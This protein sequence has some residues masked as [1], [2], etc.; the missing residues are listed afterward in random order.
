[1]SSESLPLPADQEARDRIRNNLDSTL[2]VEAGAGTGKTTELVNR[3][4][5]LVATGRAEMRKIAAITFTEAAA[6]ELR[7]RVREELEKAA[8][9]ENELPAAERE[10]CQIALADVDAA[11]IATLHG[12]SQRILAAHPLEAGL[13]PF[14]E[15]QDEVR[16]S[17]AFEERW[18]AF[19]DALLDDPAYEDVL[20]RSSVLGLRLDHL[21]EIARDFHRNWDRL[22]DIEIETVAQPETDA[23][24]LLQ[25]LDDACRRTGCCVDCD[26]LLYQYLAGV[27]RYC[28]RLRAAKTDLD[29]LRI[30]AARRKFTTRGGKQD[31]WSG[32]KPADIRASLQEA[33]EARDALLREERSAVLYQLL[34]P[35]RLFVLEYADERRHEGRVE[36]HDLLVRARDLLRNNAS[37]RRAVSD[38][39]SHLL[40]DEF[41]DTDP[42]QIDVAMLLACA[43]TDSAP[44][45]QEME[46]AE[47]KLFFV[48][49]PKQS[50]YRFRRA[51]IAL[52][53]AVQQRFQ[54]QTVRLT[55]NFR[56]LRPVIDWVNAVFEELIGE[57]TQPGQ[58]TYMA[59][60]AS[61]ES[62]PEAGVT[63]H[64]LGE[65]SGDGTEAIRRR[66][67]QEIAQTVQTAKA[68]GWLVTDED[69]DGNRCQRPCRYADI[70]LLMPTRTASAQLERALEEANIPYRVE[71]RSL[72]YETQEVRDLL[73]VLR[74]IDDPTDE[75]ALVGSLRAPAFGCGDDDLLRFAQARGRWDYRST[76]SSSLPGDDPVVAAMKALHELHKARWW[77]PVNE[78]V[79]TVIRERRF[80]ELAFAHRRPREHWQRLRFVLDQARAFVESGGTSLRQFID[81]ADLQAQERTRVVETIVPEADD[82]A[83][84]ILTVHASKG[85]EFRIVFLVGLNVT[86]SGPP[87]SAR[88]LWQ[89]DGRPEV[90]IGQEHAR[91]E[92]AGF[93]DLHALEEVMEGQEKTRLLYVAATRARDHLVVSLHHKQG[94]KCHA[95][96]LHDLC[97]QRPNLWR[98]IELGSEPAAAEQEKA[99]ATFEDGPQQ[100]RAWIEARQDRL[101]KLSR[102]SVIAA[103]AIAQEFARGE[104]DPGLQ[105]DSPV[106]EIPPWRRGRAGTALGRAVHGVLQSID[107]ASGEGLESAARAQATAEGIGDRADEVARLVRSALETASVQAAVVSQRYWRE[108]YAAVPLEGAM[109][110]G[111]VD[112]LYET[113]EGL[114]IVDYKTDAVAGDGDLLEA[115]SRY[116]LQGAAYALMLE[117]AL[118]RE[119]ADCRF[120]FVRAP[121]S[122]EQ[123]LD[124]LRGTIEL[125]RA[126]ILGWPQVPRS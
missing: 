57:E 59:L 76:P 40:I 81:W 12:F 77:K 23:E 37:V 16:S 36:F 17:I 115:M 75:V 34:V 85:L 82:D 15:I 89:A 100:R 66:E 30:L 74:S 32:V 62:P 8:R 112:L 20:L 50:I 73:T 60:E 70:A 29:R 21:R 65:P 49:D 96:R 126:K 123:S 67:A 13:P 7:D 124:D 103:T 94:G 86:D 41:Q 39:F 63:V 10:R 38:L 116:R 106:E 58:A 113:D 104:T 5:R 45:W 98:K 120:V 78:T 54:E 102:A 71:S 109:L 11:A 72:V 87:L 28:Q 118:G 33:S 18:S 46:A 83:V 27:Q 107:L 24:S 95:A 19:V 93:D 80:F 14:F 31:N 56:S 61:W 99:D 26:D 105:K 92:T 3:I 97:Q 121:H 55:Q 47:G 68:E 90:R 125:V 4:L 108:V 88:V 2:F 110:E 25:T 52:Y 119:V 79:E 6:A 111:F 69:D 42:L 9:D 48:G 64:L 35:L 43:V 1:M 22:E 84:R 101:D 117:E 51:D 53:Q 91:F 114:V 122:R 44:P